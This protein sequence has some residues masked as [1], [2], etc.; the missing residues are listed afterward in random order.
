M[1]KKYNIIISKQTPTSA[2][3][4]AWS[5]SSF[6]VIQLDLTTK[7]LYFYFYNRK[8]WTLEYKALVYR[9]RSSMM[10]SNRLLV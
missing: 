6:S 8:K 2:A 1:I 3:Y 5:I 7:K 4:V 10:M 9:A